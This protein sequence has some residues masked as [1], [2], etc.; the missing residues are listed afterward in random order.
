MGSFKQQ[1]L[2][3]LWPLSAFRIAIKNFGRRSVLDHSA[4]RQPK[5]GR[6][7]LGNNIRIMRGQNED[8]SG[9]DQVLEALASPVSEGPVSDADDLV[10]QDDLWPHGGAD[11]EGQ[12]QHHALGV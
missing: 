3:R 9:L 4:M 11:A 7:V 6:A 2:A 8:A 12:A 1:S 5:C 10:E